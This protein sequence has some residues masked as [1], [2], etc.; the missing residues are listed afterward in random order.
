MI[1]QQK[2]FRLGLAVSVLFLTFWLYCY[3]FHLFPWAQNDFRW[4]Y[5]PHFLTATALLS[6]VSQQCFEYIYNLLKG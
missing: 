2:S 6:L 1:L 4:W 5:L 3:S